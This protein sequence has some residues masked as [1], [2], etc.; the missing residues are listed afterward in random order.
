MPGKGRQIQVGLPRCLFYS[1]ATDLA[2]QD[3]PHN[4]LLRITRMLEDRMAAHDL[5][6]SVCNSSSLCKSPF[7]CSTLEVPDAAVCNS[8]LCETAMLHACAGL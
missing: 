5:H 1:K 2:E 7:V 6:A 3:Q 4:M 8:P